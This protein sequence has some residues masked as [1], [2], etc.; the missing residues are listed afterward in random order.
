VTNP[1]PEL[2]AEQVPEPRLAL[3]RRPWLLAAAGM[4]LLQVSHPIFWRHALPV[5]WFPPVGIGLVLVA[6]LGPRAVLLLFASVL[7]VSLQGQLTHTPTV[8][9]TGW[10]ALRG[11][12]LEAVLLSAEVLAAW[13]CYRYLGRGSRR[14]GDPRSATLFLIL[15]PSLTVGAFA[16]P[17]GVAAWRLNPEPS[18]LLRWVGLYWLSHALG[19]LVLAPPLLANLTPWLV[20]HRFA[21]PDDPAQAAD[22]EEPRRMSWQDTAEIAVLALFL[23]FLSLIQ[24]FLTAHRDIAGWQ[25]WGLPMLVIV[26]ASLRHGLRGG[27]IVA[28]SAVGTP[29]LFGLL[30]QTPGENPFREFELLSPILPI[31]QA[32]L[33]AEC[34]TA[35]LAASAAN[36]IR[37]SEARYRQVVTRIPVVL[38]SVRVTERPPGGRLP[39]AEVTFVSPAARALFGAEPA[40]LL[41]DHAGWL[42]LVLA[43][44]REILLAALAQLTH[45]GGT[46]T[47]EY[48]LAPPVRPATPPRLT[49]IIPTPIDGIRE[50]DLVPK[51]RE[52]WVRDTLAPQYGP[53]GELEGWDGV[54]SDITEQRAL[55]DDLRRTTSM[56][57]ALVAN[58]PAGVFFVQGEAGLPILV[59]AR[60]RHLLGRREDPAAGLV[61][62]VEAYQLCR[63]DDTPYPTDELP[64]TAALHRGATGMRDDIVVHRPDGRRLPLITWAAPIDLGGAGRHDAAV[65]VFEDLSTLRQAEAARRESEARLRTTIETM[66]E[67]LI[68]LDESG[69]IVEC[70]PAACAILGR[71][72]DVLRGQPFLDPGWHCVTEDGAALS[73]DR[74]PAT[75][76]LRDGAP[77]HNVLVGVPAVVDGG[78]WRADGGNNDA[79]PHVTRWLLVNAM[80]LA[81][82][83][84]QQKSARVVVTFAD[85]TD[86]RRALEVVRASEERY[87]ELVETL[88]IMLVQ[89]DTEGHVLY[90]NPAARTATGYGPEELR[91]RD[92]WE[93]I[94]HP[95]DLPRAREAVARALGGGTERLELRYRAKDSAEKVGYVLVEP[96][97]QDGRVAGVTALVV[98]MT[99]ERQL[100]ADLQRAQRLELIGRLAS[101][102]AH[103]FNNLLTVVLTLA[104]LARTNLPEDSPARDDLRRITYAGEQAANLAHQLLAFSKQRRVAPQRIDVNRVA[105]RTLELLRA[106]LPRAIH[107]EP[108]L[109]GVDLPVQADEMQLQQVLMNLC[110]NAR[111]AMP[112]GGRLEV[113]TEV[114]DGGPWK[115]DGGSA[116]SPPTT[117]DP[118]P[119]SQWVRLSVQDNGEGIPPELQGRIFDAFFST[120]ERGTG[121]G[122]AMVRQIIEGFGGRV[123]VSSRPGEGAR[124]DVWLPREVDGQA[125]HDGSSGTGLRSGE[126]GSTPT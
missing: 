111:D 79:S 39:R 59:N 103:D 60:A 10:T 82:P 75:R 31:L 20:R 15:V 32:N 24:A 42:R 105:K 67:G 33:L 51:A 97:H 100:E 41:G 107:I 37:L 121:L 46:V 71:D 63:P 99:R 66:A 17:L 62:L 48:R 86:H 101:G 19:I 114:V 16:L 53:A 89:F 116:P 112:N 2:V 5:W 70:N 119:T 26:W 3:A 9:G 12:F 38:Y 110:L 14:L 56:F 98:D 47:C 28:S 80:P 49:D 106:T 91:G 34:S 40:D 124:F 84:P 44:D 57:H 65:W 4:V 61:R 74:H 113:R 54:L 55:A 22:V 92:G 90:M 122:L 87:R 50:I 109:A 64:V 43:D 78:G 77:V 93:T 126:V 96:R 125:A 45:G 81:V 72:A 7:L 52:R 13:G 23:A 30:T 118:P 123:E 83:R 68:V 102:I 69:V 94:A 6:W 73:P 58:L 115:V 88:P 108:S 35:L 11:G 104:E 85:V 1:R 18:P 95:D 36:W 8:W 120:K 21:L 76:S 117:H 25:L 27:T 29:L